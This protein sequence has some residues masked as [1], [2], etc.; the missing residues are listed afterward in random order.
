MSYGFEGSG[1][2]GQ[3]SPQAADKGSL[4]SRDSEVDRVRFDAERM[5]G[6]SPV[7]TGS[8]DATTATPRTEDRSTLSK[9]AASGQGVARNLT[10][11]VESLQRRLL[12]GAARKHW[13]FIFI[14]TL[15]VGW[16]LHL[17]WNQW[18]GYGYPPFDLAIFD[19]GLWLLTHLH[20]PFV[21][22]MGR[23]LFGDH[24]SFI[25]FLVAPFY[26][27][28]PEPMGILV[29]QTLAIAGASIPIFLIA[30]KLLKNTTIATLLVVA[31]LLNPALQQGNQEQFHPEGLQVLII[32]LAIYAAIESKSV[33]LGVMV[34]LA[35][36]VKEDAAVLIVPLGVWVMFRRNRLWGIRIIVVA[37]AWAL[38]ANLAIIPSLLGTNNF[39][40]TRIPFGGLSGFLS[41]LFRRPSQLITYLRSDSRGFYV[42]QLGFSMGWVFLLAPEM[43]LLALLVIAENVL[44]ADP[45]MHQIIYHYTLTIVPILVI[46]TAYAI[47]KQKSERHRYIA[48][49]VVVV[50]AAWSSFLWGLTP[51]SVHSTSAMWTP[52]S[53]AV[54][55]VNALE[56]RIPPNAVVSAWYPLASH[57][58]HRTQIYVWPTPFSA[59]NWGLGTNNGA[60]LSVSSQVQYL[61]LPDPLDANDHNATLT[62]LAKYFH[63]VSSASG[64][65]LYQ[66][67]STP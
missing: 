47:S 31:Y 43:A 22:I 63:L 38:I 50:T 28:F 25:L 53:P 27:L 18:N 48:T 8:P 58:D 49:A 12:R 35:L 15:Y 11:F 56:A 3:R 61:I 14:V 20:A 36:L 6:D 41:T 32:S 7:S 16:N 29:L 57:L 33:L 37:V 51:Y 39:Y 23:D 13:P 10:R 17:I 9:D 44:S 59:S 55:A 60:R 54:N 45:Y 67:D 21:T 5:M 30:R 40:A 2:F 42:W 26:R 19:Q 52:G 1:E 64:I 4:V 46:G 66:R 24:T 65:G 34:A 62:S